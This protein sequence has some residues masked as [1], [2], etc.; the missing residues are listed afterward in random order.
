MSELTPEEERERIK[1]APW[2][3]FA[4]MLLVGALLL[5]AMNARALVDGPDAYGYYAI[6]NTDISYPMAPLYDWVEIDP[7]YVAAR[8]RLERLSSTETSPR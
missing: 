3:T 4:L 6:D 2:G 7:N 5:P 8:T 1:G